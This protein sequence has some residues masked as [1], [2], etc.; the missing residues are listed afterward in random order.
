[1]SIKA[2]MDKSLLTHLKLPAHV[3]QTKFQGIE[4]K[5]QAKFQ[6]LSELSGDFPELIMLEQFL[7]GFLQGSSF[8]GNGQCNAALQGMIYYGFEVVKYRE[9]YNPSKVMK[10]G[11]AL[12]KFQEQQA[13]FS[14]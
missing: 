14:A 9:I 5:G 6:A 2:I 1:M 4:P 12:Q 3:V 10:A 13:L 8:A 7:T 11:I